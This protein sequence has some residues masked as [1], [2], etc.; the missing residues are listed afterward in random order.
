MGCVAVTRVALVFQVEFYIYAALISSS[1]Q[2]QSSEFMLVV[3]PQAHQICFS[4]VEVDTWKGDLLKATQTRSN[5]GLDS[6]KFI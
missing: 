5:K 6:A 3:S 4:G 2:G 1:Y